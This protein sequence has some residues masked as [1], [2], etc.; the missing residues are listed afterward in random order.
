MNEQ[1]A[2]EDA[3]VAAGAA[4]NSGITLAE[5]KQMAKVEQ[6]Q[7]TLNEQ[8]QMT[9]TVAAAVT[10]RS[11]VIACRRLNGVQEASLYR[12]IH[13]LDQ[14]TLDSTLAVGESA[15]SGSTSSDVKSSASKKSKSRGQEQG[16]VREATRLVFAG[17]AKR[18][19]VLPPVYVSADA[20]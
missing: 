17:P 4:P 19:V 3:V 5:F 18:A 2:P 16:R 1:A 9:P 14:L 8:P 12:L 20:I 10:V 13:A 7:N 15:S 6:K 11:F